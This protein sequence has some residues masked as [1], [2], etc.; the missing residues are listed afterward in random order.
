MSSTGVP[1]VV[2]HARLSRIIS[3]M[4]SKA[5]LAR[6]E[7][8]TGRY[9]DQTKAVR[10]DIGGAH[11]LNK[12][13]EDAKAYQTNLSLAETRT[14]RTQT[15]LAMLTTESA[16]L[17]ASA[18]AGLGTG[19]EASLKTIAAD[20][21]A[22]ILNIFGALNSTEGGRA[23]FGGD[24]T[25]RP[26]LAAVEDF[27]ADIETLIAGAADAAAAETAL[28]TYF[29]D[30][31][32][33]FATDIYQGGD[34]EASSV[35]L[36]PGVRVGASVRADDQ[37]IK[38]L[39]R[40][41]AVIASYEALPSGSAEARDALTRSGAEYALVAEDDLVNMRAR[42]GVA[43]SRIAAAKDR[44]TSEETVLTSI[45]NQKTARDPYEATAE[46]QLLESQL[47]ASYLMTARL[48]RLTI[49][50]YLR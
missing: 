28:D 32:G 30:P 23:L 12:A 2:A 4:K 50:E 40:G 3:D 9:E 39:L 36:A 49:A 11:L 1:D 42:L 27:L 13:I 44:Y 15:V 45:L 20:A 21:R 38:D 14:S 46:L 5:Q 7:A 41:L 43:E 22:T 16:R 31:A 37:S 35:E 17:G 48:A 33:G 34:G 18:I 26:P 25:D 29:N 19:D 10:G 6:T 24:A 8:V 47:E